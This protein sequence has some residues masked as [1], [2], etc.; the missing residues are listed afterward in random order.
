[1][2]VPG[3]LA[4]LRAYLQTLQAVHSG[5][6][7]G[8]A[9]GSV[10]GYAAKSMKGEAFVRRVLWE[11]GCKG[12]CSRRCWRHINALCCLLLNIEFGRM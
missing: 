9:A 7:L 11:L 12:Q 2:Q 10:L 1:M 6:D 3:L 5:A 4:D 8:S